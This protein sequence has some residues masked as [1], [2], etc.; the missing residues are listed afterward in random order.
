MK[1]FSNSYSVWWW[2]WGWRSSSVLSPLVPSACWPDLQSGLCGS[3]EL[4]GGSTC[5]PPPWPDLRPA[6]PVAE[7]AR[8]LSDR[9][10][11]TTVALGEHEI[12]SP[13]QTSDLFAAAIW[14]EIFV[15]V[16]FLTKGH[17]PDFCDLDASALRF[18]RDASRA[19]LLLLMSA[20]S[21]PSL[22]DLEMDKHN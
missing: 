12:W 3:V 22:I 17:W 8:P 7:P 5:C 16:V 6:P 1:G 11:L 4:A 14:Q 21:F 20:S 9:G 10:Q 2:W 13:N 15:V 19:A 18:F